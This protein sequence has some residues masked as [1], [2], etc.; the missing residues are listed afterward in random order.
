M[1]ELTA[2]PVLFTE[3]KDCCGC[4]ACLNICPK[5]AIKMREDECGF[6]YP[7]IDEE[8]CIRCGHCKRV[9]AF[10]NK[11]EK[12]S[13]IECYAAIS[14]NTDQARQSA[15]AG[16]F[17]AIATTVIENGGIV[18]GAAFDEK[19]KVHHISASTLDQL[20]TLQGSKYAHSDIERIYTDVKGKVITGRE[21]LFS[22]TPCQVAGLQGY[23]GKE[24]ENLLTIDIVCHGV[25]SNQM[26]QDYLKTLE[27]KH[28]G[29]IQKFTFRDKSIGWGINGSAVINGKKIKIW[30]SASSYLFY[31]TKGWIYRENCYRCP[32]ACEHRPADITLGDYWGIEKQ[33]PELLKKGGWDESQGISLMI[34]NT[35]RGKQ[36]FKYVE[37]IIELSHSTF[38][39]ASKYNEQL[40]MPSKRG[41]REEIMGRFQ[42][43]SWAAVEKKFD[44][45]IG[46]RKYNSIIKSF[47]PQKIKRVIKSK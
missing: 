8:K 41:C 26:F 39:K 35:N 18:Y 34:F 13:P 23:L 33:H 5:Q 4:G 19:W 15:S 27:I 44:S 10:Q 6:I 30:Q 21:V 38:E 45:E 3:K 22:G 9:C 1:E 11:E 2:V 42:E 16:I 28:G 31:F 36:Y 40:R 25:P 29:K 46:V 20:S 12:N 43:E 7:A 24:Y 37:E 14:K 47:I 17:A 32:Y